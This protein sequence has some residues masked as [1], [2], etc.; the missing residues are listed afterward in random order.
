M[1]RHF[2]FVPL[3]AHG[4]VNPTLAL[5][6]ELSTRGH[7]VTYATSAALAP[8]V[9]RVGAGVVEM[10]WQPELSA[11]AGRGYTADHMIA[12]MDHGVT[13]LEATFSALVAAFR[14]DPPD[15]VCFDLMG[16]PGRALA[17]RLAVPGV[18]LAPNLVG[19]AHFSLSSLLWPADLKPTDP[20]LGRIGRRLG[21]FAAAHGL[22]PE[23]V[24]PVAARLPLHLVFHPREFQ[25]AGGTFGAAFRFLGPT[26]SPYAETGSWQPPADRPVLLISLG[27]VVNNRPDILRLCVEAFADSPWHVVMATGR[28]GSPGPLPVNVEAHRTVPQM[29]VLQHA[30]AFVSHTG[31]GSTMESI[32]SGVPLISVPQTPEQALNGRRAA[33]LGLGI[34]LDTETMTAATLRTAVDT[35]TA[36]PRIRAELDRWR[37]RLRAAD[38][39]RQGAQALE[40]LLCST[41]GKGSR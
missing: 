31:M 7:R 41:T 11:L 14:D 25:I 13:E 22:R 37:D 35:V 12:M 29:A 36:D 3:A 17:D 6:A 33:E 8:A 38:G 30:A 5:A 10:P 40:N 16:L 27:T 39:A 19:N 4:H 21:S 1:S 2:A 23:S 26:P 9:R 34:A 20:R 24:Q 18:A 15:C 32:W 28:S